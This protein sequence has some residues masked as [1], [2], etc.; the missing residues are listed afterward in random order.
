V[1]SAEGQDA[2]AKA[3]GSAP[4]TDALRQ[5]ITASIALIKG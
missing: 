1:T 5:K 3:A 2:A 4:L